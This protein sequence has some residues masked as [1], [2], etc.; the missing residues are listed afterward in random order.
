M[1]T[2]AVILASL[3]C[4]NLCSSAVSPVAALASDVDVLALVALHVDFDFALA[5]VPKSYGT[6]F[7]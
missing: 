7:I 5:L 2:I 6:Y 4:Q 1:T 3:P